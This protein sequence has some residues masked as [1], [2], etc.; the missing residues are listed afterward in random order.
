MQHNNKC[1]QTIDT[2]NSTDKSQ[3]SMLSKTEPTKRNTHS[4][5]LYELLEQT[6][7]AML[8]RIKENLSRRVKIEWNGETF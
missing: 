6:K 8:I 2:H 3:S 5:N 7:V 1:K 4:M